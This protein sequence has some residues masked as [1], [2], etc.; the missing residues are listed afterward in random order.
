MTHGTS[1]WTLPQVRTAS[2]ARYMDDKVSV[3]NKGKE[4]AFEVG[5]TSQT[6][7]EK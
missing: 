5:G 4:I 1:N 3:W 2:G 7:T 6:C